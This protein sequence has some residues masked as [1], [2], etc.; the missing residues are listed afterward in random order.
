[1]AAEPPQAD[2]SSTDRKSDGPEPADLAADIERTRE[3]LAVTLDAIAD[4]VSP[5]RVAKRTT[6]RVT[7]AVKN[8]G[9][10][11]AEAVKHAAGSAKEAAQDT[12]GSVKEAV[13]AHGT[14]GPREAAAAAPAPERLGGSGLAAA[15]DPAL[16]PPLS[17]PGSGGGL[18]VPAWAVAGAVAAVVAWLV[19]R[20]R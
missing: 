18:P 7:A 12:A 1:M 20:R 4:K 19:I 8:A 5:K 13:E 11:A 2:G 17:V 15:A 3:D 14:E 6:K 16:A 9:A 10:D